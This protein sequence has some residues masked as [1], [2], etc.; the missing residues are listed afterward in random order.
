[1][2]N[3]NIYAACAL[4]THRTQA[5]TRQHMQTNKHSASTNKTRGH[6]WTTDNDANDDEDELSCTT[7]NTK[8]CAVCLSFVAV[9][10]GGHH[11]PI[12]TKSSTKQRTLDHTCCC[13]CVC[14]FVQRHIGTHKQTKHYQ[15]HCTHVR[16]R[17][18]VHACVIHAFMMRHERIAPFGASHQQY[19]THN[20][21]VDV[22]VVVSV[23]LYERGQ[24]FTTTSLRTARLRLIDAL[25][26]YNIID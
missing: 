7:Q 19:N 5:T 11:F 13:V 18:R 8:H 16:T 26:L 14:L 9:F 1:M 10:G 2:L 12:H 24:R 4:Q 15:L 6:V 3:I 22:A 20:H 21:V 25:L 17:I 23:W